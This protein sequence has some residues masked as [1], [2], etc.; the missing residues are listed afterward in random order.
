MVRKLRVHRRAHTR[1]FRGR[2]VHVSSSTFYTKDRG[3]KGRTPLEKRWSRKVKISNLHKLTGYK[4]R[5]PAK[6]RRRVLV[7]EVIQRGGGRKAT[8]S[9]FRTLGFQRNRNPSRKAK[10]I[11]KADANYI[12]KKYG[13]RIKK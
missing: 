10:K 4:I 6:R 1:R 9:T 11:F 3:K 2:R 5:Y 13:F 7:H 8:R 12:G